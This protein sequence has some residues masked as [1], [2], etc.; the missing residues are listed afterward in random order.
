MPSARTVIEIVVQTSGER[1]R[2]IPAVARGNGSEVPAA[3]RLG[4]GE[5]TV[6]DRLGPEVGQADRRERQ[7]Q[8]TQADRGGA[9]H[10]ASFG[11]VGE[12]P[13][14]VA[15]IGPD[16]KDIGE[17]EPVGAAQRLQVVDVSGGRFVVVGDPGVEHRAGVPLDRFRRDPGQGCCLGALHACPRR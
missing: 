15:E 16:A 10:P 7:A 3:G 17:P 1:Q 12:H 11:A 9:H 13:A 5:E 6:T 14:I 4:D 8:G 2:G